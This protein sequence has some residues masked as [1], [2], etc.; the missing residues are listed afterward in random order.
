MRDPKVA[1]ILVILVLIKLV[2]DIFYTLMGLWRKTYF[3]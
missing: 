1:H 2:S 3:R